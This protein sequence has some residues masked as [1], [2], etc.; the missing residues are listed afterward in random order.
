MT[1]FR[2]NQG[3]GSYTL[4]RVGSDSSRLLLFP[5]YVDSVSSVLLVV[6]LQLSVPWWFGLVVIF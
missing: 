5:P 4:V 6:V 1:V 3:H 2:L